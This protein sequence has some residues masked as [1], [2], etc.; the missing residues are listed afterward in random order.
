[1]ASD[2]LDSSDIL[3]AA[4][5]KVEMIINEDAFENENLA[6]NKRYISAKN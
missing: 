3:V 1:M 5:A 4:L 6:E 2:T